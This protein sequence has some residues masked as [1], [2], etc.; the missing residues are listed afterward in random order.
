M[1]VN[2]SRRLTYNMSPAHYN[3]PLQKPV[4]CT[5]DITAEGF[6]D[7]IMPC[8]NLLVGASTAF[9]T[10]ATSPQTNITGVLRNKYEIDIINLS[11]PGFN[12]EQEVITIIKHIDTISPK[13]IVLVNGA[14][15]L[16]LGLPFNYHYVEIKD[17]PIAMYD[18]MDYETFVN[19]RYRNFL[20]IKFL[21][22]N[23]PK[24][25]LTQ[26]KTVY[27]LKKIFFSKLTQNAK[28][29]SDATLQKRGQKLI[30]SSIKNYVH[31][32]KIVRDIATAR[33]IKLLVVL[34]PYFTYGRPRSQFNERPPFPY[35]NEPFDDL[36]DQGFKQLEA[37]CLKIDGLRLV[38]AFKPFAKMPLDFF[39]DPVHLTELGY[40][41]LPGL[42]KDEL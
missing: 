41:A 9:G 13:Q 19:Q 20:P 30:V 2:P 34:Q 5:F 37:E 4:S 23:L 42:I 33:G 16:S 14:N 6:Q 8:E 18:E 29:Q 36:M 31:W 21:L 3:L 12:I 38:P 7:K 1:F 10:G 25:L 40:D 27:L 26:T 39:I 28:A 17:D 22:K 11:V 35:I 24:E 15:N 32:L